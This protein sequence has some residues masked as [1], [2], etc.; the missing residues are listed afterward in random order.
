MVEPGSEKPRLCTRKSFVPRLVNVSIVLVIYGA[1][2]LAKLAVYDFDPTS[3]V[4]AGDAFVDVKALQDPLIVHK[5]SDGYDGQ[6]YYSL[7]IT[8]LPNSA[9]NAGIRLD[10]P[11]HRQQRILY[12]LLAFLISLG[13]S[14]RTAGA[15]IVVNMF[16]LVLLAVF[17][18]LII[19]RLDVKTA[20]ALLIPFLPVCVLALSRDLTEITAAWFALAGLYFCI[21]RK[22]KVSSLFFAAAVLARETTL[23]FP[24]AVISAA[25]IDKRARDW[26]LWPIAMPFAVYAIWQ[27]YLCVQWGITPLQANSSTLTFP[28]LGLFECFAHL[29][30]QTTSHQ[31]IMLGELAILFFFIISVSLS[32]PKSKVFSCCKVLWILALAMVLCF[33]YGALWTND[34]NFMRGLLEL[35]V[36]GVLVLLADPRKNFRLMAGGWIPL[37]TAFL[38]LKSDVLHALLGRLPEIVR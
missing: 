33:D 34:W 36:A 26:Q 38:F 37:S 22:F 32:L 7:A 30:A 21:N 10:N 17:A 4:V 16:G 15:M 31:I 11:A 23:I 18:T 20:W 5:N 19:E 27:A 13:G 1:F 3:F 2:V 35:S 9:H 14:G 29:N 25:L 8:P 6:F 28:L 24:A 12:P